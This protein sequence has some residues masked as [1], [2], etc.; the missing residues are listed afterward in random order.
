MKVTV[1]N[2]TILDLTGHART[3]PMRDF[4]GVLLGMVHLTFLWENHG[5]A[6]TGLSRGCPYPGQ[7]PACRGAPYQSCTGSV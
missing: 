5:H 4:H 3:G 1:P 7:A 2:K 6:R